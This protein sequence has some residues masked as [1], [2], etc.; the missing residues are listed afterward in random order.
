MNEF[1]SLFHFKHTSEH[2]VKNDDTTLQ[3]LLKNMYTKKTKQLFFDL[4]IWGHFRICFKSHTSAV[5][6][7][8]PTVVVCHATLFSTSRARNFV[9]SFI[10]N[11]LWTYLRVTQLKKILLLNFLFHISFSCR[12]TS[13]QCVQGSLILSC[14]TELLVWSSTLV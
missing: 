12:L 13:P 6:R 1:L 11:I 7:N 4:L 9:S 10:H 5:I 3:L 2:H 8:G 14:A